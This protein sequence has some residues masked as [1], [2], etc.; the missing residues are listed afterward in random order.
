MNRVFW[1]SGAKNR[2]AQIPI[3]GIANKGSEACGIHERHLPFSVLTGVTRLMDINLFPLY[4]R[5]LGRKNKRR[6]VLISLRF[7]VYGPAA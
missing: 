1:P 2:T 6:K 4:P 3:P 7:P 5:C